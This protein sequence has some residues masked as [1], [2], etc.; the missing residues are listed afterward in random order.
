MKKII[1]GIVF[2]ALITSA[3][4]AYAV[5]SSVV[6]PVSALQQKI[7]SLLEQIKVLQQKIN[8][9]QQSSPTT[10]PLSD[11]TKATITLEGLPEIP[12]IPCVIPIL[13]YGA[14]HK[15]VYMLQTI[16][17]KEGYY[18]GPVTGYYGVLT[19][20]AIQSYQKAR[21]ILPSNGFVDST[22]A[23]ALTNAVALRYTACSGVT[24]PVS[25][26]PKVTASPTATPPIKQNIELI[27]TLQAAVSPDI[28]Q[29]GT[30]TLTIAPE[31]WCGGN[32]CVQTQLL[33]PTVVKIYRVKAL[34]NDVLA[35]LKSNEGK[36]IKLLGT[37]EYY[38]LEG[39]FWGITAYGVVS[40][41]DP[42]PPT[43]KKET[44][45]VTNPIAGSRWKTGDKNKITW[46][47]ESN[48]DL[49]KVG[50]GSKVLIQ[51]APPQAACLSSITPCLRMTIAPYTI[52]ES[53][54]NSG[55]HEWS[56]PSNLAGVY[57]GVQQITIQIIGTSIV[58]T[59]QE[60]YVY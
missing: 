34:N 10:S 54:D 20:A 15:S 47:I 53:V 7:Q 16:L 57:R 12:A 4:G 50:D 38:S 32:I 25:P 58:G 18:T 35:L 40:V 41:G 1:A 33:Q 8:T 30:H 23:L 3:M 45:I 52:A 21:G 51:L 17:T 6:D 55:V 14:W 43:V 29:W 27:G 19:K 5:S 24:Q 37:K 44:L 49:V 13:K 59:S 2:V 46:A 39:G 11:T 56:I 60:F 31:G 48:S 36:T 9:I 42:Q 28:I 22:T 26:T